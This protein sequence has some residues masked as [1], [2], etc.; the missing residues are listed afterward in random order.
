MGAPW[1]GPARITCDRIRTGR[2]RRTDSL[3]LRK[4]DAGSDD[5][6]FTFERYAAAT[7]DRTPRVFSLALC[8][9]NS[10][11]RARP[12]ADKEQRSPL[13]RTNRSR[14]AAISWT[15]NGSIMRA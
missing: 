13:S 11:L 4:N 5:F 15:S 12:L 3:M 6:G 14:A 2:V 8:Q 1:R 7:S 9:E 10:R